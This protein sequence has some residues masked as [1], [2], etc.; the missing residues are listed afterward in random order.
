MQGY[1]YSIPV[2]SGQYL[3]RRFE[4]LGYD[5]AS[6]LPKAIVRELVDSF[7]AMLQGVAANSKGR[8]V[9]LDF[10]GRIGTQWHDEI[11]PNQ[12]GADKLGAWALKTL[13]LGA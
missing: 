11:H 2:A 12:K 13:G 9:A 3:G 10:R 4:A 1:D 6:G 5:I 8:A 7:N